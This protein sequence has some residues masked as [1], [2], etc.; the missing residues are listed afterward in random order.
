MHDARAVLLDFDHTLFDTD[1]F[2]WVDVR[3]AFARFQ[4]DAGV[5][6]ESYT[7]VWSTGYSLE[8]HLEHLARVGKLDRSV[9]A[10]IQRVLRESF[11]DLGS[12]LFADAKPFLMRLQAENVPCFLLSFGDASWQA[13]KVHGSRIAEFF[14][15]IFYTPGEQ[16]K[17]EVV[18]KIVGRFD[19]L[20]IVDNDPRVLDGIQARHPQ[21]DTFWMSRVPPEALESSDPEVRERFREARGY[22]TL[23]AQFRH[24]RC[25][26]LDEVSL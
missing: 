3:A 17:G 9:M 11:S 6:E 5:W 26:T 7:R 24:Y 12:Y 14:Q 8:K 1:R 21:I 19:R 4:I 23:A 22:A 10:A 25:R 16:G 18:E 20:V 15:D 13:Y 2:F